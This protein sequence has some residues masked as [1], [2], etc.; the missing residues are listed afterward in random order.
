MDIAEVPCC[1]AEFTSLLVEVTFCFVK[2]D[3]FLLRVAV[4]LSKVVYVAEVSGGCS[5]P[6]RRKYSSA[7]C[8][9]KK[10]IIN[11]AVCRSSAVRPSNIVLGSPLT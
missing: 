2:V 11:P 10:A 7:I 4:C 3:S 5:V 1:L 8:G 6:C 9:L